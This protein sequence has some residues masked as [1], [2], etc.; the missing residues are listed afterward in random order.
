MSSN[1]RGPTLRVEGTAD[2]VLRTL[3]E[4]PGAECMEDASPTV[5]DPTCFVLPSPTPPGTTSAGI[6]FTSDWAVSQAIQID[7]PSPGGGYR[8][9]LTRARISA[10]CARTRPVAVSRRT[11][12]GCHPSFL[13][14][15]IERI[16]RV[17]WELATQTGP[18]MMALNT[19]Q[20]QPKC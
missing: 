12:N 5:N 19:A 13:P 20:E 17:S 2:F 1:L 11:D 18:L 3:M 16:A 6:L 7:Q 14:A 4:V 9:E 8:G 15:S 10:L